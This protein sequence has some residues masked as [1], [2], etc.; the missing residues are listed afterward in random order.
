MLQLEAIAHRRGQG[1]Q[2]FSIEIPR[3]NIARGEIIAV[4]GA[5]GSGKSTL[6]E[7]IG[8]ILKPDSMSKFQVGCSGGSEDIAA[9][10]TGRKHARLSRVRAR[11]LGFVL[12]TGGLL[13]YLTVLENIT[14]SRKLLGLPAQVKSVEE[15]C[16]TLGISHLLSRKP[17]QLS[18]GERQRTAIAR[19]LA[20]E[21]QLLLA[22]EPTAALD[23]YHSDQVLTLLI[24]LAQK[25]NLTSIIVTHD[26][27]RVRGLGLREI[28]AACHNTGESGTVSVFSG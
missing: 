11:Y 24:D 20:H 23:P 27:Q 5:S 1:R 19:A 2:A 17:Q 4:T 22:D 3:L 18:I 8:L 9:C 28:S 12:Q 15:I 6:L 10:W 25:L 7:I 13:P 21:P 14:L 26:W 16:R